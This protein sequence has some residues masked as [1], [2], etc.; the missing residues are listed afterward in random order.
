MVYSDF[1]HRAAITG[2]QAGLSP[3]TVAE[4]LVLQQTA[5]PRWNLWVRLDGNCNYADACLAWLRKDLDNTIAKADARD[6]ASVNGSQRLLAL[7]FPTQPGLFDRWRGMFHP[8][9]HEDVLY[10]LYSID[11]GIH[12]AEKVRHASAE[13]DLADALA[14]IED[15]ERTAAVARSQ[16]SDHRS[17]ANLA[18]QTAGTVSKDGARLAAL[19][20]NA[21]ETWAAIGDRFTGLMARYNAAVES[22][23]ATSADA[24]RRNADIAERQQRIQDGMAQRMFDKAPK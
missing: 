2:C 6:V 15:A 23:R 4:I 1:L 22:A 13:A 17:N 14:L 19:V 24:V 9:P 5:R 3:E 20:A 16:L 21:T 12:V 18:G 10:E 7:T 11:D 8:G